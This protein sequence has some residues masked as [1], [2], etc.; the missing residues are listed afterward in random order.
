VTVPTRIRSILWL[1]PLGLA[2]LRLGFEPERLILD[3]TDPWYSVAEQEA[4]K[5]RVAEFLVDR[6][7]VSPAGSVPPRAGGP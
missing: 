6:N 1:L 4:L 7:P 2:A 3:W 5:G